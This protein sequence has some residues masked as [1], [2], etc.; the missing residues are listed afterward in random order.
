[1][2]MYIAND[3]AEV[4]GGTKVV[5][6]YSEL[7]EPQIEEKRTAQEIIEDFKQRL[8]GVHNEFI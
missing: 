5:K 4:Y 3:I 2:L 8:N 7:V 1:M 6:S